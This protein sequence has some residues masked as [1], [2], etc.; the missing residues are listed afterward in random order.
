MGKVSNFI[1][2]LLVFAF[3]FWV[4]SLFAQTNGRFKSIASFNADSTTVKTEIAGLQLMYNNVGALYYN[5]QSNKWRIFSNGAWH[6]LVTGGGSGLVGAEN[7]LIVSGNIVRM[8]GAL[9]DSTV[10]SGDNYRLA[11]QDVN[12]F[13]VGATTGAFFSLESNGSASITSV[14]NT[15]SINSLNGGGILIND[16]GQGSIEMRSDGGGIIINENGAGGIHITEAFAGGIYIYDPN[17]GGFYINVGG[18]TNQ[19]AVQDSIVFSHNS[20]DKIVIGEKINFPELAPVA[21]YVSL[22]VNSTGA[23]DTLTIS[24]GGGITN[25]ALVNELPKTDTDGN[26]ISSGIYSTTAGNV[27]L[28]TNSL[29]GSRSISVQSSSADASINLTPKGNGVVNTSGLGYQVNSSSNSAFYSLS[30]ANGSG[31]TINATSLIFNEINGSA[32]SAIT[33]KG[34]TSK[35][36]NGHGSNLTV[37]GGDAQFS[38]SGNGGNLILLAGTPNSGSGANGYVIMSNLPT[39]NPCGSAPSGTLWNNSNVINICP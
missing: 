35:L 14:G 26:L 27:I 16:I 30:N 37:Q 21:G 12:A 15:A 24:G 1:K 10:I 34:A 17:K 6:D 18:T 31:F 23:V 9:I 3:L 25:A 2:C 13:R 4:G 7:G 28:G 29:T 33:I 36:A 11:F 5:Q 20:S 38:G 8:G 39:S 22:I 32:G 19:I